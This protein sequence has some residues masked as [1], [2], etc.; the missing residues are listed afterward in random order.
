M[1][2]HTPKVGARA[3][4][5]EQERERVNA[6]SSVADKFPQL[7]TLTVHLTHTNA[8]TST[9]ANAIK[10][11]VNIDRARS[12]FRFDCPNG[13]CVGGDFDLSHALTNAVAQ[14]QTTVVGEA[15]CA[16]W[17]SKT[18]IGT[19]RCTNILR[20]TLCLGYDEAAPRQVEEPVEALLRGA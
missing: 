18:T 8:E 15:Q 14:L 6:S 2:Y 7:K 12:V 20:Y 1:A 10:I 5:R 9:Q 16:G 4:Y 17:R 3:T 11:V 19:C 13:E